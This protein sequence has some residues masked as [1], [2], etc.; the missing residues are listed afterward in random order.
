M[1]KN[2]KSNRSTIINDAINHMELSIKQLEEEGE[3]LLESITTINEVVQD[4]TMIESLYHEQ[5]HCKRIRRNLKDIKLLAEKLNAANELDIRDFKRLKTMLEKVEL[6]DMQ[7]SN[8]VRKSQIAMA[9]AITGL[10]KYKQVY[11]DAAERVPFLEL[12]E[13]PFII[14]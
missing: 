6:S 5:E 14:S 9:N 8:L 12:G 2:L 11:E 3:F 1:S 13:K 7:L 4:K 10:E